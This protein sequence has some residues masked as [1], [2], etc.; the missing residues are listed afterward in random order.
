MRYFDTILR[1]QPFVAGDVFSMADITVI[2]GLIFARLVDLP[3]PAGLQALRAW[4]A[5]MQERPS[6]RDRV[7]MSDAYPGRLTA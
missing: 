7:T 2:G 6:V 4:Y 3:I 1:E 5:R